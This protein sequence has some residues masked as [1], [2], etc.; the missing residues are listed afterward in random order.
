MKEVCSLSQTMTNKS[1]IFFHQI[2]EQEKIGDKR[3]QYQEHAGKE[4]DRGGKTD[5][6]KNKAEKS[7]HENKG[8]GL[9]PDVRFHD[10]SLFYFDDKPAAENDQIPRQDDEDE[11]EGNIAEED[12][13]N[14]EG[15]NDGLVSERV[16][17]AARV[18]LLIELAREKS[19]EIV[20]AEGDKEKGESDQS[21]GKT[22]N[23]EEEKNKRCAEEAEKTEQ[24]GDCNQPSPVILF[25]RFHGSLFN[26]ILTSR[27]L[28]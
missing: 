12:N 13:G 3:N 25:F 9:S 16:Q 28:L 1:S 24:I 4:E 21:A 8:R 19:V 27:P 23:R 26:S 6:F 10:N 5:F 22:V 11:I 14:H 20:G 17:D 7:R 2:N 15:E 18:R